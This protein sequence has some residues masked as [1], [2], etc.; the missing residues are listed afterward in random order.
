MKKICLIFS[1]V[2]I[3]TSC[4]IINPGEVGIK[5]TLGKLHGN[6]KKEGAVLLNPFITQVVKVRTATVNREIRLNL[7]SNLGMRKL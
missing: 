1:A 7:P 5:Q 6:P 3:L 4:A 2:A